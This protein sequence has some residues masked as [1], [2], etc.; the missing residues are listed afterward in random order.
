LAPATWPGFM[1][2]T[3]TRWPIRKGAPSALTTTSTTRSSVR[4][5]GVV[6]LQLAGAEHGGAAD[7]LAGEDLGRVALGLISTAWPMNTKGMPPR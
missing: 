7:H 6:R 2:F 4:S 1:N 3:S 5:A